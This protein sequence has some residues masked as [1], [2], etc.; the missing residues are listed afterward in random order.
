[1]TASPFG[2]PTYGLA[3]HGLLI[4]PRCPSRAIATEEGHLLVVH[5]VNE[6]ARFIPGDVPAS[7]R[8]QEI[9]GVYR[10]GARGPML[11]LDKEFDEVFAQ[12]DVGISDGAWTAIGYGFAVDLPENVML[13]SAA[14]DEP[15]RDFELHALGGRD[16]LIAFRRVGGPVNVK[17]A[18]YQEV[19][20]EYQFDAVEPDG[21]NRTIRVTELAYAQDGVR[22][23]QVVMQV[24]YANRFMLVTAQATETRSAHLFEAAKVVAAT[25]GPLG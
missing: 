21:E 22:W 11:L 20:S 12:I 3:G 10:F 17:P 15:D 9:D 19:S 5:G 24:P 25:L 6:V 23:R 7:E 4:A 8:P 2:E 13:L 1:M 14:A 18:P 16:E